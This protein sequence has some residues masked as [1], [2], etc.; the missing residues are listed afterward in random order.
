M[1]VKLS[2]LLFCY[3]SHVSQRRAGASMAYAGGGT[4]WLARNEDDYQELASRCARQ[5]RREGT[6][7]AAA[8]ASFRRGIA[9]SRLFDMAA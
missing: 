8:A 3:L 9:S 4:A 5:I 6:A 7:A 2:Y 1:H